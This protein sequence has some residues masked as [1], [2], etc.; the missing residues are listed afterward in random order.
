MDGWPTPRTPTG[1]P[2]SAERKQELGRTQSGGGDLQ[3]AALS[4]GWPTPRTTDGDKGIR[5]PEGA[6]QE[7]ERRPNGYDLPT[8]AMVLM[9]WPTP[10]AQNFNDG[11]S[12]ETWEA[13]RQLNLAKGYNGNGQGM[14]LAIAA[15]M[16]G[17]PTPQ[18]ADEWTPAE[19]TE[20]TMRRGDPNGP[21]RSTSGS[22]AKDTPMKVAGWTTPQAMEPDAPM[23]PSRAAT[24]RTTDYL[25]RQVRG[26]TPNSS[27]AE[28]TSSGVLNPAHSRWLMGYPAS[29][30]QAAPGRSEFD[31]WQRELTERPDSAGM[32]TP[33]T[34]P[35]PASS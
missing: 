16:A 4:A 21:L 29:W 18:T 33:S 28:T 22:L 15:L 17:W 19:A 5:T 7:A 27:T 20:N 9:G 24:G 32:E 8:G 25:G 10:N 13:R 31:S 23:R 2:E 3:A 30:D 6:A 34:P 11:E 12:I 1:G 26:L 35:L 14:P